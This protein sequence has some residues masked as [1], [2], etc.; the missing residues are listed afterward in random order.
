[1]L[2]ETAGGAARRERLCRRPGRVVR[3]R[4][5]QAEVRGG[6]ARPAAL[7]A[8]RVSLKGPICGEEVVRPAGGRDGGQCSSR[9]AGREMTGTSAPFTI[10]YR[11]C[12]ARAHR[13]DRSRRSSTTCAMAHDADAA[14]CAVERAES[15]GRV[16]PAQ[17]NDEVPPAQ[18]RVQH[19][20]MTSA[21]AHEDQVGLTS[22]GSSRRR[23]GC[24]SVG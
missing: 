20:W 23:C 10:L 18:E 21:L 12:A 2:L 17:A 15:A 6:R 16:E 11:L 9:R 14:G 13:L 24:G 4:R 7:S 22:C 5:A 3:G 19:I 1:L 8:R